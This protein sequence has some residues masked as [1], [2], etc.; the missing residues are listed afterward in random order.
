MSESHTSSRSG[1]KRC[2]SD[3]ANSEAA[4]GGATIALLGRRSTCMVCSFGGNRT[5][6]AALTRWRSVSFRTPRDP[7]VGP[8]GPRSRSRVA[9]VRRA[10]DRC[11]LHPPPPQEHRTSRSGRRR[12]RGEGEGLWNR[13]PHVVGDV[14]GCQ[15]HDLLAR[16]TLG[17]VR[18]PPARTTCPP[19]STTN[20]GRDLRSMR[21]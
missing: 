19:R 9:L 16:L 2:D 21:L 6:T 20:H 15:H 7:G 4:P 14:I 11:R 8:F 13:A 12:P 17:F 3:Q 1:D 10:C 5:G 18:P